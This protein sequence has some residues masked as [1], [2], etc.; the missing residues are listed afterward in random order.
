MIIE[1]ISGRESKFTIRRCST[2]CKGVKNPR[3]SFPFILIQLHGLQFLGFY[4]HPRVASP[5]FLPLPV[6]FP[7]RRPFKRPRWINSSSRGIRD[8]GTEWP[9]RV[10][11]RDRDV[12][13]SWKGN[14]AIG[15]AGF[16][17]LAEAPSIDRSRKFLHPSF[18]FFLPLWLMSAVTSSGIEKLSARIPASSSCIELSRRMDFVERLLG[19]PTHFRNTS[20]RE[21]CFSWT[22]KLLSH[23]PS[24]LSIGRCVDAFAFHRSRL[25][26]LF[27]NHTE[28][29]FRANSRGCFFFRSASG[30]LT[31]CPLDHFRAICISLSLKRSLYVSRVRWCYF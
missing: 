4:L 20:H 15:R 27:F 6:L 29:S 31:L 10:H 21:E 12:S 26:F 1:K 30:V 17:P 7:V 16:S 18:L 5:R 3:R 25:W 19:K 11:F 28:L 13:P 2:L 24:N 14:G 9:R 23:S 8:S 22:L